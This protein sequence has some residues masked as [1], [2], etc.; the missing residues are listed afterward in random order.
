MHNFRQFPL[1][2]PDRFSRAES[3]S[4]DRA[5]P[6]ERMPDEVFSQAAQ[7]MMPCDLRISR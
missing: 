4:S 1:Q 5:G 2:E 3:V 7:S 6:Q